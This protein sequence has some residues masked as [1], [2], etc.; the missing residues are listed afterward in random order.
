H[1]SSQLLLHRLKEPGLGDLAGPLFNGPVV[2]SHD[3]YREVRQFDHRPHTVGEEELAGAY[4]AHFPFIRN[5]V[6]HDS[7]S[8]SPPSVSSLTAVTKSA[9]V[10]S[11]PTWKI[12]PTV[13]ST[14]RSEL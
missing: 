14:S 4:I 6:T 1:L 9:S 5:G 13:G 11:P 10:S 7:S 12:S 8:S 3:H 2:Q